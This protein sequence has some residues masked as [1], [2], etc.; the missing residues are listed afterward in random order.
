MV[1]TVPAV[2]TVAES[3]KAAVVVVAA[4]MV[5]ARSARVSVEPDVPSV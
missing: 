4:L 3:F 1:I 5:A 2:F